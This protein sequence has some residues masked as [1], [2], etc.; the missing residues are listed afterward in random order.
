MLIVFA[1]KLQI[2]PI[3]YLPYWSYGCDWPYGH[4]RCCGNNFC[5][6]G[7]HWSAWV[8][9]DRYKF[10]HPFRRSL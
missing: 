6:F 8:F 3:C 9:G 4:R 10:G 7:Y 2:I 1:N 5:R